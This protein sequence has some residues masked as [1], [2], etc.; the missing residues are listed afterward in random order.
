MNTSPALTIIGER[1]NS[2]RSCIARAIENK[3]EAFIQQEA[4]LQHEAGADFIDVNAGT[5]VDRETEYLPWLVRTVQAA[6][7][8]PLSLDSADPHALKAALKEHRGTPIINS[9]TLAKERMESVL[10]LALEYSCAIIALTA[11]STRMPED[12][13]K[14]VDIAIRLIDALI[15]AGVSPGKIY[16][17]PVVQPVSL[18]PHAGAEILK[19]FAMIRAARPDI[20]LLCGVGN[21]S[22]KLPQRT[23]LESAF[24][25]MAMAAG[26]DTAIIDPCNNDIMKSVAAAEALLGRDDFCI[27][28]ITAHREGRLG[29]EQS[30]LK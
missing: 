30:R 1:I 22:F 16:V 29:T 26:V 14:R 13:E 23:M 28:Y 15:E 8:V 3:D 4:R 19:A 10:P 5:F 12:T 24:L 17:D 18:I 7:D 25:G 21:I 11:D 9:I 2:S 6:V 20:H 27:R